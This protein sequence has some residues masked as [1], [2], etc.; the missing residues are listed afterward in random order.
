[1]W[2]RPDRRQCALA[3]VTSL[4]YESGPGESDDFALRFVRYTEPNGPGLTKQGSVG[5]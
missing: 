3:S 2:H 4:V 1:M 5:A